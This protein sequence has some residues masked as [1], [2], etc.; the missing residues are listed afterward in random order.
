VNK[1]RENKG[2]ENKGRESKCAWRV[3]VVRVWAHNVLTFVVVIVIIPV[4]IGGLLLLLVC[5]F[6]KRVKR[7]RL[8]LVSQMIVHV[9]LVRLRDEENVPRVGTPLDKPQL[10]VEVVPPQTCSLHRSDDHCEATH[11]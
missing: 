4:I 7:H 1:G 3:C 8:D 2:T 11:M 6:V 5:R 9:N 10:R